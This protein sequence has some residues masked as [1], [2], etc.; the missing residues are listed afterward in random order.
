MQK[1]AHNNKKKCLSCSIS[2]EAYIIW[3]WFLGIKQKMTSNYQFQSVTVYLKNCRQS[4]VSVEVKH[5]TTNDLKVAG[6]KSI[7]IIFFFSE[8]IFCEKMVSFS[9]S[10]RFDNDKIFLCNIWHISIIIG[11]NYISILLVFIL[12]INERT[13]L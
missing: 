7:T 10:D 2:Q 6:H 9:N 1:K 11:I 5:W 12:K 4:G 3:S 8:M 13:S